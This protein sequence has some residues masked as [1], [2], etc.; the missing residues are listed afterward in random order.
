MTGKIYADLV[1]ALG[2]IDNPNKDGSNPHFRSR[3]ATLEGCL[4]AA[5][6]AL[7][8]NNL[9]LTQQI[10][11]E[12]DRL[13][14][15]LI[16]TSGEFIEDGGVP[17]K[18]KDPTNPQ[19]LASAVTYARR[20]GL[21]AMLG[22]TGEDDDGNAA[23]KPPP[24]SE[25]KVPEP[26]PAPAIPQQ[27]KDKPPMGEKTKNFIIRS[28]QAI[29]TAGSE[30]DLTVWAHDNQADLT[31]LKHDYPEQVVLLRNQYETKSKELKNG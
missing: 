27:Q 6:T 29:D 21:M 30:G 22:I 18:P 7:R 10:H 1:T 17:L 25:I 31:A 13:V 8:E 16:H 24:P 12:P 20:Y 9:A 2:V 14:T 5:K 19:A 4:D 15:R 28:S 23:T 11:P 3:Y 26:K